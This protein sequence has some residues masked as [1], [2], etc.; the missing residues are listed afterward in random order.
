MAKKRAF[1]EEKK[2]EIV[3]YALKHGSGKAC[4]KYKI[5]SSSLCDWKKKYKTQQTMQPA[6]PRAAS[7]P[8]VTSISTIQ[9]EIELPVGDASDSQ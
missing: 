9:A 3:A 8:A 6:V 5:Y 1:T 7:K 2:R 4:E